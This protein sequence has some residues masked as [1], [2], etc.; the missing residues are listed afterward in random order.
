[1]DIEL[2]NLRNLPVADKLRIVEQLWDDIHESDER[3]VVQDWHRDQAKRRLEELEANPEIAITREE[4]WKRV[5]ESN[6]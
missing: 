1:M 4:L 2:E 3:L 6:G 5:D